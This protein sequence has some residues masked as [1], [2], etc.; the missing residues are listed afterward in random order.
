MKQESNSRRSF[1]KSTVAAAA[2]AVA[3]ASQG[4]V[5]PNDRIRVAC[6]GLRGRGRAHTREM[7]AL[8]PQGVDLVAFC[9]VDKQ[10]MEERAAAAENETGT[11]IQRYADVRK[12]LE[13]DSI[14][15]ITV[16]TPN[17]W[18]ALM[19]IWACQAGKDVYVEK[20]VS[21][22][23]RE[24]RK[25][26]EA[27]RKYKRIVQ[28]GTQARS[29]EH[30]RHQMQ[31]MRAGLLGD[32]YMVRG[33]CYKQR[34]SIGFKE[35]AA[36]PDHLDFDLWL[37][38]AP[39]QPY[40]ANLVH[41]NWHWFWDFGN[42]D[43][44][45]QGI[46]EIDL[47][48]WAL[49]KG[50]VIRVSSTGGR[51]GYQDQG[52][53]PNSLTSAFTYADGTQ[54]VFEVR[55]RYTN[56]EEGVQ[57]GNIFYGTQGYLPGGNWGSGTGSYQKQDQSVADWRPRFGFGGTAYGKPPN[58]PP[59]SAQPAGKL[60]ENDAYHF[61][62]FIAAVRSRNHEELNADILEGHR[63]AMFAHTANISYR[64]GRALT[65]DL[66]QEVFVGEGADKA[67]EFLTRQYREPCV[68]P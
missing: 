13:N 28:A 5:S 54:I 35:S 61:Q 4:N 38:P 30:V 10:L 24:G 36:P 39:E 62:N 51:F 20:P 55:G 15:V 27:A 34:D 48:R 19:T 9:D 25:M 65:F 14:D 49:D 68:V 57:I 64:L 6:V 17:H 31:E 53:T 59:E 7:L 37:G 8:K 12:L 45:N 2:F 22:C 32:I 26:V 23:I 11:K 50:G 1:L 16:A 33:M 29:F 44:G 42:G 43:I 66:S 18:H 63:S 41:Y 47:A 52:Q 56:A 67:N 21:W 60:D 58:E 3:P 46:H 40:H